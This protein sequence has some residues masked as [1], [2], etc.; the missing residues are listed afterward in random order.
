[1]NRLKEV[2]ANTGPVVLID[3]QSRWAEE[4]ATAGKQLR[5]ILGNSALR[6]DYI[7]STSVPGLSAKGIVDIQI[8]VESLDETAALTEKMLAAHF[9]KRGEFQHD[10]LIGIDNPKDPQLRK[11]NF[12]EPEGQRRCHLHAVNRDSKISATL[13]YFATTC[14]PIKLS[15]SATKESNVAWRRSSR[16]ALADTSTS[17]IRSWIS[18]IKEQSLGPRRSAGHRTKLIF[19]RDIPVASG[20]SPPFRRDVFCSQQLSTCKTGNPPILPR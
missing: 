7:G 9:L 3:Y 18:F 14:G 5:H 19:K 11:M 17:K 12:R 10:C 2:A 4:F 15:K 8:T 1:M 6:I 13:S 20:S 16:T